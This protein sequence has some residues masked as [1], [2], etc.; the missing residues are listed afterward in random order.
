MAVADCAQAMGQAFRGRLVSALFPVLQSRSDDHAGVVSSAEQALASM[1]RFCG[2][3]DT[4]DLLRNN[5]DY[6]VDEIV[7]RLAQWDS[8]NAGGGGGGGG[9]D[10]V[11]S[12][13]Q[14][15]LS[16]VDTWAM[17]DAHTAAV[18]DAALASLDD[19]FVAPEHA[20]TLLRALRAVVARLPPLP[21]DPAAQQQQ[22]QHT[23]YAHLD[24]LL[25]E[26]EAYS[27]EPTADASVADAAAAA[28]SL[29][30]PE[31]AHLDHLL[32]EFE[33]F[34]REPAEDAAAD[35][36]VDDDEAESPPRSF[37]MTQAVLARA[38][39]Y[40]GHG[41]MP[42]RNQATLLAA[43]CLQCMGALA[44]RHIHA[45]WP[46]LVLNLKRE[47]TQP[48]TEAL[49]SLVAACV[50]AS[51][52][53]MAARVQDDL[54]PA[55]RKL[56]GSAKDLQP[57]ALRALERCAALL[58]SVAEDVADATQPLLARRP[59]ARRLWRALATGEHGGDALWLRSALSDTQ[60]P[61]YAR[62]QRWA[63]GHVAAAVPWWDGA[64]L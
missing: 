23:Q 8:G 13:L 1:A 46:T 22:Q 63:A 52:E 49:L 27:R 31:Y 40:F 54:W 17:G 34:S 36:V 24:H 5:L 21:P 56:L 58:E 55:L 2:Y 18:V 48:G 57:L 11:A 29:Q 12:L 53:F 20:W 64:E 16:R 44:K 61:Y 28:A 32:R 6:V 15:L 7:V 25:R 39:L 50:D 4:T 47:T 62:A 30:R 51:G 33:A 19:A 43:D 38:Q 60:G 35:N 45:L 59:E 10:D 37:K 3:A 42:V 9:G 26:F 14:V 41:D